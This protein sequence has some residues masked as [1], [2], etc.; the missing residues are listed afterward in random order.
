VSVVLD[1]FKDN[2]DS[3]ILKIHLF[4]DSINVHGW[5]ID[6]ELAASLAKQYEDSP[7]LIPPT[8]N[9]P[10]RPY[11]PFVND[12]IRDIEDIKRFASSYHAGKC[13]KTEPCT[14]GHSKFG[15]DGYIKLT[16]QRAI[17]AFD[18]GLI[19][20]YASIALYDL[21]NERNAGY[22]TKAQALNICAVRKPAYS[23]AEL[24]GSCKGAEDTCHTNLKNAGVTSDYCILK[25]LEQNDFDKFESNTSLKQNS[26]IV[27]SYNQMSATNQAQPQQQQQQAQQPV[28]NNPNVQ[29]LNQSN[30]PAATNQPQP[31]QPVSNPVQQTGV[32]NL[33]Q[34]PKE[35]LPIEDV[36][37]KSQIEEQLD[38]KKL[39]EDL[40][41]Q[42]EQ[43]DALLLDMQKRINKYEKDQEALKIK[44]IDRFVTIELFNGDQKF[45][46]KKTK[47]WKDRAENMTLDSLTWHLTEAYG[48][49]LPLDRE[50]KAGLNFEPT[51]VLA[52]GSTNNNNNN[53][54]QRKFSIYDIGSFD[55]TKGGAY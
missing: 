5:G 52:N 23:N 43:K 37:A 15:Y 24:L 16:D 1:A 32:T 31:Q 17:D 14:S 19:P 20:R 2:Q 35:K 47:E 3:R 21:G 51:A 6:R 55:S 50:K 26:E 41:A 28:N 8:L 39:Y 42:F 11:A 25:T 49:K 48:R 13:F 30:Q 22:V 4:D 34:E 29:Q 7:Y 45:W 40:K 33:P 44:E 53:Q 10:V 12:P 38:H 54:G 27:A 18:K 9:H 36:Q 46:E